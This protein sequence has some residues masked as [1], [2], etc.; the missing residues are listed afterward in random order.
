VLL[1]KI[2]LSFIIGGYSSEEA[3]FP[4]SKGTGVGFLAVILY[5]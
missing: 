3:T 2:I 4:D 5:H 1:L